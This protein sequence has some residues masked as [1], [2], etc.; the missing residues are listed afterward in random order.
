MCLFLEP[1]GA[2]LGRIKSEHREEGKES[3]FEVELVDKFLPSLLE[4]CANNRCLQTWT[5]RF[6][7]WWIWEVGYHTHLNASTIGLVSGTDVFQ[8]SELSWATLDI[9]DPACAAS[10]STLVVSVVKTRIRNYVLSRVFTYLYPPRNLGRLFILRVLTP[11]YET[12]YSFW[13]VQG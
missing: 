2:F 6:W 5:L 1:P 9:E 4:W 8:E 12:T 3:T 10:G 11:E 13:A 7:A